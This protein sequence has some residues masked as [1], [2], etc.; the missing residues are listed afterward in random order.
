[1]DVE[2]AGNMARRL[3]QK[4]LDWPWRF[5]WTWKVTR[6]GECDYALNIVALSMPLTA[7][8]SRGEVRQSILHEIAHALCPVGACHGPDWKRTIKR[9]GGQAKTQSAITFIPK[10]YKYVIMFRDMVVHGYY[11]KP[12]K[13]TFDTVEYM[14]IKGHPETKGHLVLEQFDVAR[15]TKLLDKALI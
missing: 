14:I 9:L 8:R 6:F 10:D 11:R 1:M 5:G 4:H 15:H 2:R 12:R 7:E 3:V 13:R